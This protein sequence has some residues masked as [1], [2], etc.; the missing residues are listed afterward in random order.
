MT[1]PFTTRLNVVVSKAPVAERLRKLRTASGAFSGS[2]AISIAPSCV[3]SVTHSAANFSTETPSKVSVDVSVAVAV[4]REFAFLGGSWATDKIPK[5]QIN[6]SKLLIANSQPSL[7]K[8]DRAK[9]RA[10]FVHCLRV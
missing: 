4:V 10:R 3:S 9:Q 6:A 8:F 1:K 2:I 5:K 7:R